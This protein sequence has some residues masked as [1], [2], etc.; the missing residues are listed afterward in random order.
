VLCVERYRLPSDSP[1]WVIV[2]FWKSLRRRA[3]HNR[4]FDTLGDMMRSVRNR[5]CNFQTVA[6]RVKRLIE[7][8]YARPENQNV[9]VDS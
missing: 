5:L 7:G 9:P 2:R 6:G 8:C 1:A 4:L 3:T